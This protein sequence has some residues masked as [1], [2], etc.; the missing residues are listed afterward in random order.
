[1]SAKHAL[2]GLLLDGPAYP[3]QLAGR[4]EQRL[5]PAWEVNSGKLYQTVKGLER[6]GLIERTDAVGTKRENR[7][8]YAITGEGVAEFER[9][10]EDAAGA[11]RL[12]RR[13]LLVKVTF[14]GPQRLGDALA[15]VDEYELQCAKRL[16]EIAGVRDALP[17]D[18]PLVRADH[19]LLRLNLGADISQLEAELQWARHARE[20][21]S[22][23]AENEALWP[24]S[25]E[26]LEAVQRLRELEREGARSDL[27]RRMADPQCADGERVESNAGD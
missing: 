3:Y 5:G 13:P 4:L 22:W 24:S 19:L 20:M 12:S 26:R 21:L 7:H 16:E 6:D 11:V 2:L 8:V 25:R 17:V 15:K 1:M 23:L 27:F 14:A 18:G 9:W 10:F